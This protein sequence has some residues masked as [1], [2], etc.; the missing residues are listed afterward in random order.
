MCSFFLSGGYRFAEDIDLEEGG[1]K[2]GATLDATGPVATLG[3]ALG[4]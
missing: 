2:T 4:F 1:R 3:F